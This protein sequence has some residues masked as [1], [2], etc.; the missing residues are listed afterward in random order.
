[1]RFKSAT[2]ARNNSALA[3][4]HKGAVTHVTTNNAIVD[5]FFVIGAA[6]ANPAAAI[7]LFRQAFA[8][9][10][11][12]ACKV[13]LHSRDV[14]EGMGERNTFREILKAMEGDHKF[15][16]FLERIIPA[17]PEYG[18]WDD[19]LIFS[20][21]ENKNTAYAII[22]NALFEAN[23]LAAK[24]MPRKGKTAVEL[25]KYFGLS[26]KR[27][28]KLLVEN[29]TTVEQAM[30]S[31]D[32]SKINYSHVPS[33]AAARYQKA[34]SRNDKDRYSAYRAALV[35]GVKGVKV[36][37]GAIFPY[38]VIKGYD[39]GDKTVAEA[40]W[41]SLPNL[42][43][44][45]KTILPMPDTSGSMGCQVSPG[46]SAMD[47]SV[48]LGLYLADKQKGPFSGMV[49]TFNDDAHIV[50][51]KGSFPT[52]LDQVRRLPWGGTTNL[53]SA[54]DSIL[55]LAVQNSLRQED[56]PGY[57]LIISDMEFDQC[58]NPTH[59]WISG[60][61]QTAE[62]NTNYEV[63]R[64][65]FAR[66]GYALPKVVFWNVNGRAGNNPVKEHES[67]TALVSGFSP[68]ILK[69]ILSGKFDRYD[70]LNVVL[71]AVDKPRYDIFGEI[72]A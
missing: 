49:C 4:T 64:S 22:K 21:L 43:V 48:S 8:A 33:I 47:V 72:A 60:R 51:L 20:K 70:P 12:L 7:Q 5:L 13:L 63:A 56:L 53:Q 34:F 50:E 65:K 25:T 66:A 40:Q 15:A 17:T 29:S 23:G 44:E 67:G 46:L 9:D 68:N 61:L 3:R 42:L 24:W 55:K 52:R 39:S 32:W 37:A 59:R 11:V 2:N 38:D 58:A 1:M 35:K 10:P 69:S 27:Y 54:F 57:L 45:G 19:L 71:D 16:P 62:K 14:R 28:R 30:C 36:N 6:R 41:N 26:P 31:K 18:R